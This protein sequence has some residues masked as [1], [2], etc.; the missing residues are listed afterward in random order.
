MAFKTY[1]ELDVWKKSMDLVVET[2]RLTKDFPNEE[3]YGLTSQI[4]RAAVSI[5][6]NIAE[7]H[8]RKYRGD[9]VHHLCISRGSLTELETLLTIAVRLK[10]IQ[11]TQAVEVW[12]LAQ[13]IGQML[14]K[15]IHSLESSPSVPRTPDPGSR[16]PKKGNHNG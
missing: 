4:Q 10:F 15:L 9:Y 5:P 14:N 16:T 2:Y 7:G 11:R 1:R 3:K 6:S 8:G 13:E 12:K